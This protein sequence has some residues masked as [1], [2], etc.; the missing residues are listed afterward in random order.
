MARTFRL[1][2][3]NDGQKNIKVSKCLRINLKIC[4]LLPYTAA[5]KFSL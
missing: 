4:K 5:F 3:W 2:G 1:L